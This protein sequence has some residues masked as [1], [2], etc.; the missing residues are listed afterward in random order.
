MKAISIYVRVALPLLSALF[1]ETNSGVKKTLEEQVLEELTMLL[2]YLAL[3]YPSNYPDR[4]IS[5]KAG[6]KPE[7]CIAF[8]LTTAG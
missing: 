7:L 2:R 1:Y 3:C 5:K 6:C 4:S 8:A